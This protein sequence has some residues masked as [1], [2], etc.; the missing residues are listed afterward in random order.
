MDPKVEKIL[1]SSRTIAV[2]GIKPATHAGQPAHDVPAYLAAQGY[3]VVPVPV[4]YPD[5]TEILGKP[6]FR[7]LVAAVEGRH[8]PIDLVN[9]FRRSEDVAGHLEDILAA[10][11]RAV[12]LQL[13][14]RDDDL[15]RKLEAAGIDVVQDRCIMVDHRRMLRSA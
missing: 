13:G 11:P 14:I 7:S 10:K 8:Q 2:L 4:Y 6:V 15:A 5:V 9:V 12:W 1:K 3:D